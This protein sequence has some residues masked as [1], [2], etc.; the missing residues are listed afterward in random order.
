MATQDR[1]YRLS[2][3]TELIHA[4]PVTTANLRLLDKLRRPTAVGSSDFVGRFQKSF[5]TVYRSEMRQGKILPP[6]QRC[7]RIEF[8]PEVCQQS[9]VSEKAAQ[10]EEAARH[11]NPALRGRPKW[12][13]A[14]SHWA[15]HILI[16]A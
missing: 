2:P 12:S 14:F 8:Q 1:S 5:H 10:R 7:H 9:L 13:N 3:T 16:H 6:L 4:G 15:I 11:Q